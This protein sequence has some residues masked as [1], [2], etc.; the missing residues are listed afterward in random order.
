MRKIFLIIFILLAYSN[1]TTAAEKETANHEVMPM[2][3]YIEGK[4][5]FTS[6][7][8]SYL[9][10]EGGVMTMYFACNQDVTEWNWYFSRETDLKDSHDIAYNECVKD[11]IKYKLK[12]CYLFAINDTIVWGKDRAFIAKLEKE[13]QTKVVV[14]LELSDYCIKK[15][16]EI[17]KKEFKPLA[18]RSDKKNAAYVLYFGCTG[19][20]GDNWSWWSW[21]ADDWDEANEN[22][23]KKC[24]KLRP[25]QLFAVHDKIVYGKD[26]TYKSK[27]VYK[28]KKKLAKKNKKG[29]KYVHKYLL[30]DNKIFTKNS[31]TTLKEVKFI[32][33]KN[34]GGI[35]K[36][37]KRSNDWSKK[38]NFKSFNFV[39]EYEDDIS[40]EILVEISKEKK[41]FDKAKEEALFFAKMYGQM[42]HFLKLYNKRIFI[43]NDNKDSDQLG[44]WW[45]NYNKKEFHINP[46]RENDHSNG[47][48]LC[49]KSTLYSPC[50]VTV[51]HELAHVIDQLTGVIDPS[52]WQKA[53]KLDKK[54]Y[55]S[56]YAKTN[57]KEDFAE[58]LV[59]WIAVRF[60]L[61]QLSE[62]DLKKFE[63][64]ISNRLKFFDDQ[65]FKMHPM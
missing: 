14:S 48:H 55:A 27:I 30:W 16:T 2:G 22:A 53:R 12:D 29:G 35:T 25:C 50:A 15:G 39:A 54:R 20:S 64:Y 31:P 65:K 60:K 9:N 57:S 45:V 18:K 38:K 63:E 34:N 7:Y 52:K 33:E 58:S 37:I 3:C 44:L 49:K 13:A 62:S 6:R 32:K 61:D 10:E 36:H 56:A 43:H 26:E 41:D 47:R 28:I 11:S 8:E 24:S 5:A 59:A 19:T 23:N 4:N 1:I 21:T 40:V 51:A 17:F 42:P 46:K